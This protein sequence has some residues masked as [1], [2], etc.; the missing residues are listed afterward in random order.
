MESRKKKTDNGILI[1]IS[2]RLRKLRI[3]NGFGIEKKISNEETGAIIENYMV[4]ALKES[5]YYDAF[6]LA[7]EQLYLKIK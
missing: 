1:A 7:T 4:P 2:T 3:H 5:K 6:R